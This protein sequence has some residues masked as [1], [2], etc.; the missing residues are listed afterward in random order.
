MHHTGHLK[1]RSVEWTCLTWLLRWSGLQEKKERSNSGSK[2]DLKVLQLQKKHTQYNVCLSFR[3]RKGLG[4]VWAHVGL[5]DAT[6]VWAHVVAH[7]VFPLK[8]LLA[9]R[10][11]EG[12]LIRVREPVPIQVVDVPEGL[13]TSLTCMV[14]THHVSIWGW[15]HWPLL[16]TRERKGQT[17][18]RPLKG[19][20]NVH[21]EHC[22][23]HTHL[24]TLMSHNL[25]VLLQCLVYYILHRSAVEFSN[26]IGHKVL[27]ILLQQLWQ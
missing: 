16:D 11:G 20:H 26:P 4:A 13:P 14:L 12:L 1:G 15:V 22:K 9:H 7:S 2:F 21:I 19:V 24:W 10:T 27:N 17:R 3:P 5:L 8:A 6:L 23:F 18:Q 25:P